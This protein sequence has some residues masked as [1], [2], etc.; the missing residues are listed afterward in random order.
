M[1]A[2]VVSKI[3][4]LRSLYTQG[5]QA[6]VKHIQAELVTCLQTSDISL[7]G[8]SVDEKV[9]SALLTGDLSSLASAGISSDAFREAVGPLKEKMEQR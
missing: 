3:T 8:L 6:V 4:Q 2:F 1:L 7:T 5:F 9:A